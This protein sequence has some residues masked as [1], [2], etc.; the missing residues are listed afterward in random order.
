M[1]EK[2]KKKENLESSIW[3]KEVHLKPA[4]PDLGLYSKQSHY[5]PSGFIYSFVLYGHAY[6]LSCSHQVQ[7]K[8]QL[9]LL[10]YYL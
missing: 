4:F 8:H 6:N 9:S 3:V 2:K 7:G 5:F 1:T 10:F